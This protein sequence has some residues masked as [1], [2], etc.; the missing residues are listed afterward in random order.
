L[1][2]AAAAARTAEKPLLV[3]VLSAESLT[4]RAFETATLAHKGLAAWL[5]KHFVVARIDAADAWHKQFLLAHGVRR[6]PSLVVM[7]PDP[8]QPDNY[9]LIEPLDWD[10]PDGIFRSSF[11]FEQLVAKN[12]GN[13]LDRA[14][15]R[16][17]RYG[18][19]RSCGRSGR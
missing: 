17:G 3:C 16:N 7:S 2:A 14:K 15:Q 4:S 5:D 9:A 19:P 12:L 8:A 18:A 11:D 6:T 1:A 10:V 13:A